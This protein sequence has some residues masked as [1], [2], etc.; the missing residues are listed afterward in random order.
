MKFQRKGLLKAG[1]FT[2][3]L[4]LFALAGCS[5]QANPTALPTVVLGDQNAAPGTAVPQANN[6]SVATAGATASGKVV[7]AD[8]VHLAFTLQ[9]VVKTVDVAEGEQVKA[10]QVLAKLDDSLVQ[11]QIQ[12]AQAAVTTAQ[13]NY[14]LLAAGPTDEQLR[15]AEAAVIIAMS[16][17]SR[18][19]ES[20]RPSSVAA[21]QSAL[22][23]A[24]EA[25]DKLKAGPQPADY[26]ASEATF[27]NARAALQQAQYAYDAAYK[28]NPAAIGASAQALALQQ[29]TNDYNAAKAA[30][31]KVS[32]QPDAAQLEAA[33]AQVQ[34]ARAA[35]DAAVSPAR[36]FDVAQA[37][38]QVDE[39]QAQLDALKAGTRAQQLQAAQAQVDAAKA[40]LG[41]LQAQA[42]KY[43]LIAPYDATVLSRTIQPG[44]TAVPGT[45]VMVLGALNHLRVQTTDLSELDVTG[46]QKGQAVT[47]NVKALNQN[48]AGHVS[49]L[50]PMADTIG[51]D[52]VYQ[53]TIDLDTQPAGLRVG[54]SVNVTF[55]TQR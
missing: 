25:Y 30:Y 14:D 1:C 23:A 31:D 39:A 10:G 21:A 4:A 34:A 26:A 16:G 12:Q 41:V 27:L 42:Q 53:V 33:Q 17:Y 5:A 44:E 54:M 8:E 55:G 22:D 11:A 46:V 2:A 7:A 24:T 49:E 29:A 47:V 38:A 18:T 32:Q 40:A 28:Q 48:V 15:Q 37:K 50:A 51:G 35:L 52:V 6:E 36:D 20:A 9:E 13:A 19:V 3:V 43:A 45:P